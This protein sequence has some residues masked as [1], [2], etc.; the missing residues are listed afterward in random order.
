MPRSLANGDYSLVMAVESSS[1]AD[2]W[3]RILADRQ[4]GALSCDCPPWTFKQDAQA[5]PSGRS[6]HHTRMAQQLSRARPLSAAPPAGAFTQGGALASLISATQQQWPGLRGEWSIEARVAEINEKPYMFFLLTLAIGNGGM[7]TGVTGFAQW[8]RPTQQHVQTRLAMWSGYA[9]ASEVARIGGFPLAGQPPEHFRVTSNRQSRRMVAG[10][11]SPRTIGLGDIL[12][13][14]DFEDLGDGLRP[15]ERAEQ[16]LRLF[17]G[18]QLYQQLEMFGFLDVSSVRYAEEQRVYRLRRDPGK[19]RERRVRVFIHG[20]Y[21]NDFCIVR[22]QSVPE[23]DHVLS[24]FLQFLSDEDSALSVVK[25]HNIFGPYSDG[26][27]RET[28]APV[29]HLR[30]A[31]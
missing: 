28:I 5:R 3:Y 31:G 4:T 23:A 20:Q 27:E 30:L 16:T 21:L 10:R 19:L 2:S 24:I 7:A 8:H 26:H 15:T 1:C 12:R 11:A 9:I 14:G 29:W 18:E 17:L 6:C 25:D 13:V 22:A